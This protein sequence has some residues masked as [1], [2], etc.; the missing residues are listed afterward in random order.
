MV[1]EHC[2]TGLD[3]RMRNQNGEIRRKRTDTKVETLRK[4][5]G[6]DFAKNIGQMRTWVRCSSAKASSQ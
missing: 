4:T 6:D 3:N 5:Y 2:P 1:T